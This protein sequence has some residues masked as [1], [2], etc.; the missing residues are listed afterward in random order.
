MNTITRSIGARSRYA[1]F[2]KINIYFPLSH[3]R[4]DLYPKESQ[5]L[6]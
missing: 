6:L 3:N 1:I 5:T 4:G 2:F